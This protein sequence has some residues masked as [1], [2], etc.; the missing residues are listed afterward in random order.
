MS[1][2]LAYAALSLR[3][4]LQRTTTFTSLT[5]I[6]INA[7]HYSSNN[8]KTSCRSQNPLRRQRPASGTSLQSVNTSF[9]SLFTGAPGRNFAIA[10]LIASFTT[11]H[12]RN[13]T[14]SILLL[15]ILNL[16]TYATILSRTSKN[17]SISS[18]IFFPY[19]LICTPQSPDVRKHRRPCRATKGFLQN[20]T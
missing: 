1:H 19:N 6:T 17:Y 8:L 20:R 14:F 7:Q 9:R 12:L 4:Q 13:A 5:K 18:K 3:L 11:I 15:R 2:M 16:S 10:E